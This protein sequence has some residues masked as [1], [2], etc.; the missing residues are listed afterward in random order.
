MLATKVR[1]GELTLTAEQAP[2]FQKMGAAVGPALKAIGKLS[3]DMKAAETEQQA[4]AALLE[5]LQAAAPRQRGRS[6]RSRSAC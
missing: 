4:G 6:T 3:E 5:Q 1:K 2:Q